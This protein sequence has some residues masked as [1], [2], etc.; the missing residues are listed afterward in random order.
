MG[1]T[2][3]TKAK[4]VYKRRAPLRG[5]RKRM[6][7][8]GVPEWASMSCTRSLENPAPVPG[9]PVTI[10]APNVPYRLYDIALDQFARAIPVSTAYQQYRIKRVTMKIRPQVDTFAAGGGQTIP[11]LYYQIDKPQALSALVGLPSLKAMGCVPKR[12]DD[13]NITISWSPSVLDAATDNMAGGG[14][15]A[16][17]NVAPWLNTTDNPFAVPAVVSSVDHKGITWAVEQMVGASGSYTI[18]LV[19]DIQFRKPIAEPHEG[20]LGAIDVK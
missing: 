15:F 19:V 8:N 3:K 10:F 11:Q 16:K 7:V 13:K 2:T 12:L 4:R 20:E 9:L 6:G 1:K 5:R 14:T 18:E 17:Y